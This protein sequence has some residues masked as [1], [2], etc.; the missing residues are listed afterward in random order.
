M[1]RSECTM[2]NMK[3]RGW[4]D[5]ISEQHTLILLEVVRE[6]AEVKRTKCNYTIEV[7]DENSNIYYPRYHTEEYSVE[8]MEVFYQGCWW[9]VMKTKEEKIG[10]FKT[11]QQM[12]M[13]D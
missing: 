8:Y 2:E 10:E 11:R 13:G 12:Y 3:N 4:F 1:K 6:G 5:N 7:E 9:K